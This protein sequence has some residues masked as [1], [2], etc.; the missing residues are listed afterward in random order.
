[1]GKI[2]L[3]RHGETDSNLS[4]RFQGQMDLPLNGAG[5]AQ[6]RS[7]AAYMADKKIDAIYCSNMLRA[8]MTAA[9]LAMPRYLAYRPLDSLKEV[10]FGDW[11]GLAYDEIRQRWPEE[12]DAFLHR[13]AEWIPPHGETFAAALER[14]RAAYA[15]IFAEQGHDK[16][17]A[18]VSHGGIIRLQLCLAL[19]MPL[20][21]LWKLSVYNVSVSTLSDW[22]GELCVDTMN[23]ANFVQRNC[24]ST[25]LSYGRK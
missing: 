7:M 10:S 22:Q 14:C 19:G 9:E 12:M 23:I 8:R 11:E 18:I 6:A 16:N 15:Q 21:N 4:H 5:L 13:P 2:Y 24:A 17:I 1:M 25:A 20:N 3:I